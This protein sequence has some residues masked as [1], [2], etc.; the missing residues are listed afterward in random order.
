MKIH[1]RLETLQELK[2]A[3]KEAAVEIRRLKTKRKGA[4][5]GVVPALDNH[6][7]T[8]RHHHLAYSMLRSRD[9][10]VVER[11]C[12]TYNWPDM[13]YVR[14]IMAPV[15]SHWLRSLN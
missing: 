11:D 6:R 8:V 5:Y 1:T 13:A 10:Y 3:L 9:R 4:R 12:R 7:Y 2:E 14:R 15:Q